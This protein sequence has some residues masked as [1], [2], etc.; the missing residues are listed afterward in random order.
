MLLSLNDSSLSVSKYYK[1]ARQIK[2]LSP[3]RK[4][5]KKFVVHVALQ[6]DRWCGQRRITIVVFKENGNGE[7]ADLV[8]GVG[9]EGRVDSAD[10]A[11]GLHDE[12]EHLGAELGSE[13]DQSLEDAGEEGLKD[14]S[15]LWELQLITIPEER[16][17][18]FASIKRRYQLNIFITC[19]NFKPLTCLLKGWDSNF[20]FYAFRNNTFSIPVKCVN[21]WQWECVQLLTQPVFRWTDKFTQTAA[22]Y[23]CI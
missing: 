4:E 17:G 21:S 12:G 7:G 10:D 5:K 1:Q 20:V 3:E 14:V 15:A 13:L 18:K 22:C 23:Q 9:G 16:H 8:L 2:V 6:S 11:Q 19:D